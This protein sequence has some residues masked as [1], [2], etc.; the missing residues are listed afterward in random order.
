MSWWEQ[1]SVMVRRLDV[2]TS[3]QERNVRWGSEGMVVMGASY[4]QLLRIFLDVAP[5]PRSRLI[6]EPPNARA[7]QAVVESL[8]YSWDRPDK[9]NRGPE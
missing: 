6:C 8:F 1:P 9:W 2:R 7:G 5:T 3:R 4:R